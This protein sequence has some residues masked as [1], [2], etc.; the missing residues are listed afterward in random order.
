MITKITKFLNSVTNFWCVGVATNYPPP[1]NECFI[2][3]TAYNL[4]T[5]EVLYIKDSF[6]LI[7]KFMQGS[8]LA[9]ENGTEEYH[10][11]RRSLS[12]LQ[13]SDELQMR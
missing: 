12:M 9:P 6:T 10:R 2:S 13:F 11:L 8:S 5:L 3:T 4:F 1:F 7:T